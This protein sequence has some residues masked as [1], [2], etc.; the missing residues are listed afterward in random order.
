MPHIDRKYPFVK[1]ADY[2]HMRPKDKAIWNKF[3]DK[4]PGRFAGCFYDF[5]VG[6]KDDVDAETPQNVA[7]AWWD[8]TRWNIDVIAFDS[9]AIYI[10][11]IKPNAN[12]KAIGQ[13]LAYKV[14]YE[15]EH[16]PELPVVAV[17]ITDIISATAKKVADRLNVE[18][19]SV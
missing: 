8:L 9:Q 3:I 4:N 10:I 1:M 13:A 5:L 14:L 12:A 2:P 17:V 6:E 16:N 19:W 11:E 7:N 18:M 15:T